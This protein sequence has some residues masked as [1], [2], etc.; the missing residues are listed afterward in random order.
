MSIES[1]ID[2][3]GTTCDIYKNTS[4]KGSMGG[5]VETASLRATGVPVFIE[6]LTGQ[7]A[8][9]GGQTGLTSTHRFFFKKDVVILR[10]DEIRITRPSMD[11][12]SESTRT[13][14]DLFIDDPNN[15]DHHLEVYA[16][17]RE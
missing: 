8:V 3:K 10:T 15:M 5:H 2:E 7:E 14:V 1:I 11:D 9:I 16:T 13:Y 12:A 4:S 6:L 17:L